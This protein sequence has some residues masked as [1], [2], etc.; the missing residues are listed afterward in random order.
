MIVDTAALASLS[1]FT[2]MVDSMLTLAEVT[3]SRTIFGSTPSLVASF[4]AKVD[5]LASSQSARS[6]LTVNVALTTCM[7]APPG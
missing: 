6:P 5:F 3:S 4:E 2:T 7:Y 1:E